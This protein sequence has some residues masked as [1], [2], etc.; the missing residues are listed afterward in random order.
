[1][2]KTLSRPNRAKQS[3]YRELL[4][5]KARILRENM[6]TPTAQVVARREEPNDYGDLAEQ[7]HEEWL[8]LN[9]NA[10]T[11]QQLHAI[12]EALKR[13]DDGTYG[14]CAECEKPISMK[15]LQAVPW[16]KYC[17]HCEEQH[18]SWRN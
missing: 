6:S 2:P 7:S 16:A 14:I 13:L 5:E 18:G 17:V 11:S 1:M 15:R 4:E 3:Q 10:A 8:F 9:R 12:E